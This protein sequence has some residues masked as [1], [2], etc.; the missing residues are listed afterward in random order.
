MNI[1]EQRRM[2]AEASRGI[3]S[4]PSYALAGQLLEKHAPAGRVLEFGAGTGNFARKLLEEGFSHNITCADIL[5]APDDLLQHVEWIQ[6]DLNNPLPTAEKSFDG[7]VSTEVIEHLENPRAVFREFFR[8]LRPGGWL[9]LTT[10]NQESVR[11]LASLS[12]GRHFAA[13]LGA[14]YPAHITAL[15]G[16]DLQRICAESGFDTPSFHYTNTG[17]IPKMTRFRWP[18]GFRGRLFSDNF[19]L[20]TRKPLK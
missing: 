11:S 20:E 17:R 7:I 14:S 10:P 4:G 16:L 15:L 5:P 1:T 3:S 8:L 18:K 6:T 13:F 19:A 9:V 2:A 12:I